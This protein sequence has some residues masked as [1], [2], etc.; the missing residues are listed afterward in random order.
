MDLSKTPIMFLETT[1]D[2]EAITKAFTHLHT[3][4]YELTSVGLTKMK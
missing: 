4:I 1:G 3:T 2:K